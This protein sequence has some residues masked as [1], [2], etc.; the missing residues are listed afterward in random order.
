[1]TTTMI[2]SEDDP[3]GY[4]AAVVKEAITCQRAECTPEDHSKFVTRNMEIA[5]E[6]ISD[7]PRW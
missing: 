1:M 4:A 3:V 5:S 6:V 7:Q 2:N